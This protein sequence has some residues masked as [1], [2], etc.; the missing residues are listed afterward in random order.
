MKTFLPLS[1]L[2][3]LTVVLSGQDHCPCM[4]PENEVYDVQQFMAQANTEIMD[5]TFS[6]VAYKKSSFTF[7]EEKDIVEEVLPLALSNKDEV[8]TE[9]AE[10]QKV[11][12]VKPKAKKKLFQKRMPRNRNWKKYKGRCPMF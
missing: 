3:S 8:E 11:F 12:K 9:L 7:E 10:N 1:Y 5:L 2:L 4:D 6:T